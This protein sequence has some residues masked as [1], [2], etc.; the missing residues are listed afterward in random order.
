VKTLPTT[1]ITIVQ[2]TDAQFRNAG[3]SSVLPEKEM[4][5]QT[6]TLNGKME[7]M[8]EKCYYHQHPNGRV[9]K[10]T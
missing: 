8:P 1:E 4:L 5:G 6:I 7:V 9:C 10:A 3:L 2:L